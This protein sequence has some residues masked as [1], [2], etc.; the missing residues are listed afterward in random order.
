LVIKENSQKSTTDY[1]CPF[2]PADLSSG[3]SSSSSKSGEHCVCANWWWCR[4]V[5]Q[6]SLCFG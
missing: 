3:S 6:M 4:R 2:G 1:H 5:I